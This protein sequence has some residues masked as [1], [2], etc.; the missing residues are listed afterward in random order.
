MKSFTALFTTLLVVLSLS[1]AHAA[2]TTP[3]PDKPVRVIVSTE[4]NATE[5]II[6]F[7]DGSS[8]SVPNPNK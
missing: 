5:C 8:Q 2:I 7:T 6:Y 1:S 4:C 3:T